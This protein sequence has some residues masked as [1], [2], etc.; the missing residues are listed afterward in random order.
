MRARLIVALAL[1]LFAWSALV[2]AQQH[3]NIPQLAIL[4]DETPAV[5]AKTFELFAG[6]LRDLGY[7][8]GQNITFAR[9][10]A[11]GRMEVLP[12][13]AA[14]LVSL[15]PEVVLAI[16][17]PAA[18]AAKASTQTIPI[19]F[20]RISDPIGSGLVSGLARPG[21]NL[22]GLTVQT[23]ELAAKRLE[24]LIAAVPDAKR[25]AALWDPNFPPGGP[26]LKEIERAAQSLNV[27]LFTVGATGPDDFEQAI[28]AMVE[29]H[30]DAVLVLPGVFTENARQLA[31]LMAKAQLA[32]MFYR[33]EQ[34]EAGG[35]MSY[36]T[37]YPDMYRR[38]ATYVDKVLKGIKPA[39][40]PVEQPTKF[41]LVINLN[42][43]KA[44]G[45]TIPA[46]LLA[47]AD[48]VIE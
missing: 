30:A 43:A 35:L 6:G 47:R 37:S 46:T 45:L 22:T 14:E 44:I 24:L 3:A 32:A 29:Q 5:A 10:Y 34:V 18:R 13:L 9:R 48:E 28:R 1:G 31:D 2:D 33:K 27:E 19:I 23:R 38:A 20:A 36:G 7:I 41:E 25:V 12:S 17:T 26:L 42:T 16:G 39:D 21:G 8:E 11:D 4:S 40:L 15:Q